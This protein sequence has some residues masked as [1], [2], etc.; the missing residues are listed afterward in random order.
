MLLNQ[1]LTLAA[2]ALQAP[3]PQARPTPTLV[4]HITVDQFRADYLERW[5]SQLTGGLAWL[6][7]HGA[8]FT[9]AYQDHA[10]TETA[11][12]HAT[13]LSGRNP[14]STGIVDNDHGVSDSTADG[15]LLEVSGA[16]ASPWRFRGTALFDW[17]AARYPDARALSVSRKDRAA[18]L[19]IGKARQQVYWYQ[20]GR[21]TTSRYYTTSLPDWIRSFN[22][23]LADESAA[24]RVWDLLLPGK[25]YAEPDS[26][27]NPHLARDITFP[28]LLP[29]SPNGAYPIVATPFM[30]SLT[31]A[32]ALA[33]VNQLRLGRGPSPDLL[34]V[35]LS[36]TDAIGH[37]FGPDSREIHDQ[38]LRLDRYL[39]QFLDSLFRL[40]DPQRV[41]VSLTADHGVTSYVRWSRT[42]GDT[43]ATEVNISSV[44]SETELTLVSRAGP[45]TWLRWLGMGMLVMDRQRLEANHLDVD[46]VVS[47]LAARIRAVPGVLRTDTPRSLAAADTARDAIA[48][49]WLNAIPPDLGVEL[50][51]TLGPRDVWGPTVTAEHGQPSDDDAH[52]PLIIVGA[53]VRPGR[54]TG[55]VQVADLAPTLASLA[56]VR[57]LEKLDGRILTEALRP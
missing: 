32:L 33:G 54:Y 51:V 44:L 35:S 10:M 36:S 40:R 46:N 3:V 38:V 34:A 12:G 52:V 1:I 26:A 37:A 24:L 45:G 8:V 42:H 49:R 11:P 39:G 57:P 29:G 5:K 9:D 4:V 28:H 7:Q 43:A 22:V 17:I 53:G 25:E 16:G 23:D 31:L 18:I 21:F 13:V 27:P 55:R 19:P 2:V 56:G 48:R 14:H 41:I 20:R 15:R 30:D 6:V 50:V 47:D